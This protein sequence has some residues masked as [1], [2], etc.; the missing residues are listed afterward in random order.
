MARWL[1]QSISKTT[2]AKR[3]KASFGKKKNLFT[4]YHLL[5]SVLSMQWLLPTKSDPR[6]DDQWTSDRVMGAQA[7]LIIVTLKEIY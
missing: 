6:K 7:S 2:E 1:G 4:I 5:R 3:L